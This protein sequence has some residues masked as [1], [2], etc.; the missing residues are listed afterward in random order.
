M[1]FQ[2]A[3][4]RENNAKIRKM[5]Y[6]IL[7]EQGM[8]KSYEKFPDI[9]ERPNPMSYYNKFSEVPLDQ[10][11]EDYRKMLFNI[12]RKQANLKDKKGF[13][14]SGIDMG[15][16]PPR[17]K[18]FSSEME[19]SLTKQGFGMMDYEYMMDDDYDNYMSGS[20][21]KNKISKR[22]I[23]HMKAQD[24][25]DL[26]IKR[27]IKDGENRKIRKAMKDVEAKYK[28]MGYGYM[29]NNMDDYLK[30]QAFKALKKKDRK[31][32]GGVQASK[33]N[34]WIMFIKEF[35]KK[36]PNLTGKEMM[37]E[38]KYVYN[39]LKRQGKI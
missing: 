3:R 25:Y 8:L 10:R 6:D 18:K 28:K 4:E 2:T 5:V 32:K 11:D 26:I 22:K 33:K 15:Y 20:A 38:A 31:R 14:V 7:K 19:K 29:D 13:Q 17:S 12:L 37:K 9:V 24:L 1:S 21:K 30:E 39:D 36:N 16:K 23:E 27:K 35:Q 34:K